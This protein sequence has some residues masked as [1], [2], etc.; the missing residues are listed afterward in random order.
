MSGLLVVCTQ[1][2][3]EYEPTHEDIMQGYAVWSRCP[4]CRD[5]EHVEEAS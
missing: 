4:E 3:T 1:C 2:L 5:V